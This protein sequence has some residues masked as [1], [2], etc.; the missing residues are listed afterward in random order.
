MKITAFAL[1]PAA[2][3][4]FLLALGGCV[5]HHPM[6]SGRG[7]LDRTWEAPQPELQR[8]SMAWVAAGSFRPSQR[9]PADVTAIVIHT[10]EGR[11]NPQLSFAENQAANYRDTIRYF[12]TND[13]NVSAHFVIGPNGEICQMVREQDI[14]H[15]QTYYNGRSF[16]IECAGWSGRPETWTPEL[17]EALV[18]LTAYL[19]VKWEVP[20]SHPA[21]TA[22]EG[23]NRV[24]LENGDE[25]FTGAGLVGHFQIQ[26]WNKTDPGPYFPWSEFSKRVSERVRAYGV[27][28]GSLEVGGVGFV[29]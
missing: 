7:D 6:E 13:R 24:V 11:Y 20:V 27:D 10:T 8:P 23:P 12:Q 21:G 18:E 16:G 22:Y 26:P 25:R 3:F 28:P 15:T 4:V 2:A 17:M 9:S 19:C 14:A 29:P 5:R 1:F